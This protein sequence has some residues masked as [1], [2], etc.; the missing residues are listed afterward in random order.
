M[1]FSRRGF[2][3]GLA[4]VGAAAPAVWYARQPVD[5]DDTLEPGQVE[6]PGEASVEVAAGEGVRI[7]D[8]LRGIW[9][10]RFSGMDIGL[11]DLPLQGVEMLL[12]VG[13]GG[14]SLRGFID[15]GARLRGR[16]EPR[17]RVLGELATADAR[18]VRW[19]LVPAGESA[20]SHELEAILDEVWGGWGDAGAG[21]LSGRIRRLDRPLD[22][23]EP[24]SR[25]VA[26]KRAFPEAQRV[27]PLAPALLAWLVSPGHR[28][29]HQL[30]HATRD[31]WHR[32]DDARRD[33]LRGAGWQPGPRDAER[34]ARGRRKHLNGSGEDFFFMHRHMLGQ[35]RA[36]Q[37]D[38]PNWT[39]LPLPSPYVEHDRLGFIRYQENRDGDS[40]PPAWV[41][42]D[43]EELSQWLHGIKAAETFFGNFQ[44]WESQYQD[45][46]YLSRLTLAQFGSEVELNIHDWLHMRWAT[47]TRDPSNG[48]PV[49]GDRE[50]SD[51]AA[52]WFRDEND[53]LGD[54]FSSHVNPVFWRF[55]GWIDD[56]IEDWFRAHERAHPGE[57]QRREVNGV[58]WFAPGRW[59]EVAD[60]WLGPSTHGCGGIADA[61]G[62]AGELEVEAMKLAL[63][64]AFS[65]EED[66]GDLLRR[67]PRR[68]WYARNLKLPGK[69]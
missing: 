27:T 18:T 36:L 23:P 8:T 59:V 21:T 66:I 55:H 11:D 3:A 69:V 38:L 61:G 50:P 39:R 35:A 44:V 32:L 43:D 19:R 1:R 5:H 20:P 12:D 24:D 48:M 26:I 65:G 31:K 40:V 60:P 15:M 17:Y 4:V 2:M 7:A 63:R 49:V 54:P 37:P 14:R 68:P 13:P 6:T 51:Y 41:A 53:Y 62:G 52:R 56:R 30:W 16:G 34:G 33:A 64:I 29:F 46:D 45:P 42:A 25:F 28:L 57:V 47:V 10:M 22:M 67:T 58:P 9:D